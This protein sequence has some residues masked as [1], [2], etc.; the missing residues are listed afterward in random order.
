MSVWSDERVGQNGI[1]YASWAHH[2]IS[3]QGNDIVLLGDQGSQLVV[4]GKG[5][6]GGAI[7]WWDVNAGPPGPRSLVAEVKGSKGTIKHEPTSLALVH[8]P[9]SPL[10]VYGDDAGDL[11]ALDLRMLTRPLWSLS[12]AH[13]G[14][15]QSLDTWA[16]GTHSAPTASV[17]VSG[18]SKPSPSRSG[19][20]T[21]PMV[22]I[23]LQS[24]LVSGGK[25]GSLV[26]VDVMSGRVV[27]AVPLAH[28]TSS[29]NPLAGFMKLFAGPSS[30]G[31]HRSGASIS[32]VVCLQDGI[33]TCGSDGAVR[34][35]ELSP[36]VVIMK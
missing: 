26:V 14:S 33:L 1:G 23:P 31:Q 8:A 10:L 28:W 4:C 2:C 3:R 35:I 12:R 9:A 6:R 18:V 21:P 36:E 25:D 22:S 15:V 34:L 7:S 13:Q 16:S 17:L 24:L 27:D 5:E 20:T 32:S 19:A 30:S 29:K 11:H